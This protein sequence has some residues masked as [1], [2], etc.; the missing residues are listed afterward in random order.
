MELAPSFDTVGWFARDAAMLGRVGAVLLPQA[1]AGAA[2]QRL[3]TLPEAWELA[4]PETA[5]TLEVE[6][7]RVERRLTTREALSLAEFGGVAQALADFRVLQGREIARGIGRWVQSERPEL[8]AD[9]AERF[10]WAAS[11]GE[12]E[13]RDAR[14]R[15]A[16]FTRW[17]DAQLGNEAILALPATPGA[18]PLLGETAEQRLAWRN[19]TLSLT[20]VAGLS[21][22]PQITIPSSGADGLPRGLGLVAPRGRDRDLLAFVARLAGGA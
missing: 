8:G 15:R 9:I 20:A 1:K 17:L 13:E 3:L 18:A 5:E 19:R 21:G 14:E 7:R 4:D 6:L 10:A 11:L 22:L 2:F 16:R 12:E